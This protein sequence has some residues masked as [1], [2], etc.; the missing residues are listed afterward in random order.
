MKC[1][2]SDLFL[3]PSKILLKIQ[4]SMKIKLGLSLGLGLN[5]SL[6]G[7]L[8]EN[9]CQEEILRDFLRK[10]RMTAFHSDLF[11]NHIC[12]GIIYIYIWENL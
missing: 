9:W 4:L 6:D 3:D 5:L 2:S 8:A 11:M 12:V 7:V 10:L 1:I